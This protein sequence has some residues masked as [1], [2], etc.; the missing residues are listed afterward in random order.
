LLR[1]QGSFDCVCPPLRGEHTA[2][3]MTILKISGHNGLIGTFDLYIQI[4]ACLKLGV[5]GNGITFLLASSF[6]QE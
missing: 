6:E 1:E 5:R 3:R 4:A 2:L